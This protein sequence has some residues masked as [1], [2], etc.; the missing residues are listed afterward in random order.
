MQADVARATTRISEPISLEAKGLN[1]RRLSAP[2]GGSE[3]DR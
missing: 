1:P 3:E 2:V